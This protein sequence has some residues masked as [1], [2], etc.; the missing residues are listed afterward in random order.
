[1]V[2]ADLIGRRL[3]LADYEALPDDQDYEIIDGVLY[4]S[5]HPRYEHQDLLVRLAVE[6]QTHARDRRLGKVIVEADLVVDARNH[7]FSP[8]LMFFPA[9]TYAR[10]DPKK[11]NSIMP[12]LA[13]EILSDSTAGVDLLV[14]R[15]LYAE[16]GIP[17]YWIL[18]IDR[19]AVRELV[20][21]SD[22]RYEEREVRAPET[23]RPVI[24]PELAIDLG[25]LF[26]LT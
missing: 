23:L 22:G 10:I 9:E 14:K 25:Q 17:H 13:I 5:P 4:V 18:D 6:L 12:A 1:M 7:Y 26:D 19:S 24:F 20:L 2:P 15:N 16:L 21:G 8:D 11:M 3:T